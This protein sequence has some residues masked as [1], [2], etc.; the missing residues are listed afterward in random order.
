MLSAGFFLQRA[1]NSSTI[2]QEREMKVRIR[3]SYKTQAI[4]SAAAMAAVAAAGGK[5]SAVTVEAI[6]TWDLSNYSSGTIINSPLASFGNGT[7]LSLGMTNEYDYS[8]GVTG[9]VATLG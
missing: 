9:S 3:K 1:F 8:N 5:A 7:A 2:D 6:T 4:L